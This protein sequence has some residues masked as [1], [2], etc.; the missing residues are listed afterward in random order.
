MAGTFPSLTPVGSSFWR[1]PRE[2]VAPD[3]DDVAAPL[4]MA[5][6]E[7]PIVEPMPA[8]DVAL[9]AF[10][11]C[12]GAHVGAILSPPPKREDPDPGAP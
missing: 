4:E 9:N 6:T 8:A 2:R 3:E 1:E 7:G 12:W 5:E 10:G 11:E